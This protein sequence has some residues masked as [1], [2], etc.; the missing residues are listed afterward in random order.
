[1]SKWK[2]FYL[3]A[4]A[5]C[6]CAAAAALYSIACTGE[7][8]TNKLISMSVCLNACMYALSRADW[9]ELWEDNEEEEDG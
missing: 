7:D 1:M 6:V 4:A 8:V 5:V 9:E 3:A 2:W